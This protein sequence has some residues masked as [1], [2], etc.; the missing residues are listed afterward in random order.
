MDRAQLVSP[1]KVR[2]DLNSNSGH[3]SIGPEHAF[4]GAGDPEPGR[5]IPRAEVILLSA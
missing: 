4:V 3:V 5:R 1:R 2:A